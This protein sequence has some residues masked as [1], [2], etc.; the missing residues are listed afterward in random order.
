[1]VLRHEV[2]GAPPPAGPAPADW[3][4]HAVL[5]ALARLVPA[6]LRAADWHAENPVVR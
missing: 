2:M 6:S 3:A 5:A 1:M 4:D